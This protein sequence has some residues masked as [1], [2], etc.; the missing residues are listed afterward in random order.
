M[1]KPNNKRYLAHTYDYENKIS[2]NVHWTMKQ[3]E[4]AEFLIRAGVMGLIE[5]MGY[6]YKYSDLDKAMKKYGNNP[7]WRELE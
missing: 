5:G 2:L 4:F 3:F 6:V 7:Y 1:K